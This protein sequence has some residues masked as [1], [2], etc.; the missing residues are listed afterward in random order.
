MILF[1]TTRCG[2]NCC[3]T[4][5]LSIGFVGCVLIG[6]ALDNYR[7]RRKEKE[8]DSVMT[9]FYLE[10]HLLSLFFYFSLFLLY[11]IILLSHILLLFYYTSLE[12]LDGQHEASRGE[13]R[14]YRAGHWAGGL[15]P[16][17]TKMH[18]STSSLTC[19]LHLYPVYTMKLAW[20][21]GS[22][23]WLYERS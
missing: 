23:S 11:I 20:R 5:R 7:E 10:L 12:T 9:I 18:G 6:V 19:W 15:V 4:Q 2:Y 22:T 1:F 21:A 16:R 3:V 14:N 17:Q 8:S 13:T